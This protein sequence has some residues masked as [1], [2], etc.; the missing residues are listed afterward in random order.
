MAYISNPLLEMGLQKVTTNKLK[1][2]DNSIKVT[3]NGTEIQGDIIADGNIEI[4]DVT[5]KGFDN[6]SLLQLLKIILAQLN[7]SIRILKSLS[8]EDL[9]NLVGSEVGD[10]HKI[11][12]GG[13]F[14]YTNNYGE[15]KTILIKPLDYIV[16]TNSGDWDFLYAKDFIASLQKLASEDGSK[17]IEMQNESG[18]NV[19]CNMQIEGDLEVLGNV[20]FANQQ[21]IDVVINCDDGSQKKFGFVGFKKEN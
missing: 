18:A 4:N 11:I 5:L 1:N 7:I 6:Q 16:Y 8:I 3:K 9:N 21:T 14:T 19:N 2:G 10:A 20:N 17:T 15:E 13:S 12:D